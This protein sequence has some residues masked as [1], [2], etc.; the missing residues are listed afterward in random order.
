M[1]LE[2]QKEDGGGVQWTQ[3]ATFGHEEEGES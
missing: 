2:G 1:H 3:S